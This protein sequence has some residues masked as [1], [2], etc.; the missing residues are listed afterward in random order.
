MKIFNIFLC[1]HTTR[2]KSLITY[3][4]LSGT[5]HA[6]GWLLARP[7]LKYYTLEVVLIFIQCGS[8]LFK[9]C[10]SRIHLNMAPMV[11]SLKAVLT[12]NN[13]Q[14]VKFKPYS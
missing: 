13:L 10:R 14:T 1:M 9:L 2:N 8:K 7:A 6:V 3:I 5:P 12:G 11:T 4:K